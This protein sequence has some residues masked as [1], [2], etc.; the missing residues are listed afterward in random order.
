MTITLNEDLFNNDF[1][2]VVVSNTKTLVF[3]IIDEDFN[4][5]TLNLIQLE[6]LSQDGVVLSKCTNI[7][8]MSDGVVTINTEYTELLS[9]RLTKDNMTKVTIEVADE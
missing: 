1:Y 4:G 9:Q 2:S 8:G 6:L 7:I 5:V 3:N